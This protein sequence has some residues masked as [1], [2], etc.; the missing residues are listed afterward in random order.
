VCGWC[1]SS[2][3]LASAIDVQPPR[4]SAR[5]RRVRQLVIY[6]L[7]R[8]WFAFAEWLAPATRG[9]RKR[10]GRDLDIDVPA[11]S[12]LCRMIVPGW[13]HA[14]VGR[15]ER[16]RIFLALYLVLA[17][18]GLFFFG[19]FVGNS[20]LGLAFSAHVASAIDLL[21]GRGEARQ[22]IILAIVAMFA[23]GAGIY[24]PAGWLVGHVAWPRQL[25]QDMGGFRRGDLVLVNRWDRPEPGE[26]IL[27]LSH[28]E[29]QVSAPADVN[30]FGR[31][32]V[33]RHRAGERIARVIAGPDQQVTWD[34]AELRVDG[35]QLDLA[36]HYIEPRGFPSKNPFRVPAGHF[37]IQPVDV[38]VI[39]AHLSPDHWRATS[40]VREQD[41]RGRIYMIYQPLG[42]RKW[43]R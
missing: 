21:G 19:S 41:V 18:I 25:N 7:G 39:D 38:P 32:V 26:A 34:G 9:I 10:F 40:L 6:R 20:L 14:A 8:P 31:P 27:W 33:Y 22:R 5:S 30:V 12:V 2:L 11:R 42:R 17:V 3:V 15:W 24:A 23:L 28:R 1:G 29:F 16:G 37:L 35:R 36:P 13:A 43:V 4:A